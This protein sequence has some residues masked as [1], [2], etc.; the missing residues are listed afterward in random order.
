MRTYQTEEDYK[1]DDLVTVL[2]LHICRL[3]RLV[4]NFSVYFDKEYKKKIDIAR[5]V[6]KFTFM[7]VP[8]Y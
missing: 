6:D 8:V 7:V 2:Q 5:V 1:Q 4:P 3:M